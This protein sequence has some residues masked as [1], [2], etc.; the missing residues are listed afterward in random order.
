VKTTTESVVFT[1]IA[2]RRR[3][4]VIFSSHDKGKSFYYHVKHLLQD[5]SGKRYF[6]FGHPKTRDVSLEK[7][8]RILIKALEDQENWKERKVT[9]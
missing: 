2:G 9:K 4:E 3:Y 1:I 6:P 7:A 5:D 8:Q